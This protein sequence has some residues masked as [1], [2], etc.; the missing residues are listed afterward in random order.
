MISAVIFDLDGT[1]VETEELKALSYAEAAVELRPDG[2]REEDVLEAFGDLVGLSRQE[3]ASALVERFE[4]QEPAEERMSEFEADAPWEVLVAIRLK[5]YEE[6]IA[7]PEKLREQRY[8]HNID[9]LHE[10]KQEGYRLALATM[11]HRYQVVKVL[12]I[13]GLEDDFDL[14][15]TTDDVERGKPDPEIDLLIAR[16]FG[17]PPE[18]FLVIEDSPAGIEAALAAGMAAVA[19]TTKLTRPKFRGS[20]LLDTRWVVEDPNEVLDVV[21]QRIEAAPRDD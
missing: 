8:Q 4:L 12:D 18:E 6:L 1:L 10:L 16:D 20:Q 3:V 13:L 15:V 9:L 21:H 11:S 5:I 17:L 7:D 19:I 2:L 14:V